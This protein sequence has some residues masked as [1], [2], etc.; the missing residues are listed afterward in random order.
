MGAIQSAMIHWEHIAPVLKMPTSESE[1]DALVQHLNAV[2]DAGGADENHCLA[3]LA[4]VIGDLLQAYENQHHGIQATGIDALKYLMEAHDLGQK[5]LPEIGS[6]GVVSEVLSGKR[7][8]NLRQ[9][10][11]LAARFQVA[12]QV[13]I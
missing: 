9:I 3:S 2:L 12:E 4:D 5:D 1:Y 13:F 8:L 10:K 6:Q 11:S 7:M